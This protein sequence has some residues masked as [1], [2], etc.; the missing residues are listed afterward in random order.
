MIR[1]IFTLILLTPFSALSNVKIVTSITPLSSLASMILGSK[2]EIKT[3]ASNQGCPHSYAL[4]PSD[5]EKMEQADLFIYIDKD[6]DLFAT[7]LLNKFHTHSVEISTL[8]AINTHNNNLHLWLLPKNAIAI[9]E[10]I[11]QELIKIS[12]E[13]Q[14]Y[15]EA[16]LKH[17]ISKMQLLEQQ[18]QGISIISENIITL[19]DSTEYILSGIDHRKNY[20]NS[21]YSSLKSN[22]KLQELATDSAKCFIISSDQN[23]EK[24][25]DLLGSKIV[26]IATENWEEHTDLPK[27]YYN[28]YHKI[29]QSITTGCK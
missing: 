8:P 5:L 3:I 29:L 15:F 16:N 22:K 13:N 2:G 4:K 27:A 18:R 21:D 20:Q 11:T 28:E 6:F 17:H 10:A 24:Y 14:P 26:S 9:L 23:A 19:S 7:K 1:L 25:R 12:P